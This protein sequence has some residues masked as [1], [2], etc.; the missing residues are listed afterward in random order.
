[1][2][3]IPSRATLLNFEFYPLLLS[4]SPPFTTP[5]LLPAYRRNAF[6]SDGNRPGV[7]GRGAK[8]ETA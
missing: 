4:T 3:V 6:F 5:I 7:D 2:T 8:P 1:M